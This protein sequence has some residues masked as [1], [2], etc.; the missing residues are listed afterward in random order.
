VNINNPTTFSTPD[1]TL[2]TSNSSGSAGALRADDTILVFDTTLPAAVGTAATGSASTAPRRDHVHAGTSFAAP[3]LTLGTANGAGAATTAFATNSTILAFDTTVPASVGTNATGSATVASRRDHVHTGALIASGSYTGDGQ[4]T[5]A[6]TGLGFTPK[7]LRLDR[8]Y[9]SDQTAAQSKGANVQAYT[10]LLDNNAAGMALTGND[11]TNEFLTYTID[12]IRS[13]DSD[14]FTVGDAGTSNHPN[15]N[16]TVYDF[17]A[18][19]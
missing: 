16:T 15:N 12:C 3:A 5:Q 7:Y 10:S 1:L 2:S 4:A 8:R 6:V 17:V 18:I 13:F 9:T 19:G 11:A 14:G